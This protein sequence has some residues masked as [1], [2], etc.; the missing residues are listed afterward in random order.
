MGTAVILAELYRGGAHDQRIDACLARQGGIHIAPTDRALA[1]RVGHVLAAAKLGST[2][3]AD[4]HTVAV[5][6][7]RGGGVIITGDPDDLQKLA[8]PHAAITIST[9]HA[10]PRRQ[11]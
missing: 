2:H 5:A 8:G 4:A 6:I 9:L 1:R 10:R 3:L 11:N 7:S